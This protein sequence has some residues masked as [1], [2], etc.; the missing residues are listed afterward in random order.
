MV[1]IMILGKG[2]ILSS[3]TN[4]FPFQTITNTIK[5]T[6]TLDFNRKRSINLAESAL[7]KAKLTCAKVLANHN[8]IRHVGYYDSFGKILGDSSREKLAPLEGEGAEEM[9]I[10]NG[11]AA[12][13]IVLWKRSDYLL[14]R[15]DAIIMIMDKVV[16]LIV[17]QKDTGA[18][19]LVV[20]DKETPTS[21]VERARLDIVRFE[22]K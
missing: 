5:T 22:K 8:K 18:Y 11:T 6:I 20:F 17:P 3:I 14:G 21:D 19:F 9:H 2:V 10:L 15:L 13:S 16:D 1:Q 7:A 4:F 12:S